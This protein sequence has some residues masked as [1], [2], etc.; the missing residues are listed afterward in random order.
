MSCNGVDFQIFHLLHF[1][2]R[3]GHED[4]QKKNT[5][6]IKF[7]D[8][9]QIIIKKNIETKIESKGGP[10]GSY[11]NEKLNMCLENLQLI[12]YVNFR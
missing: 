8:E 5:G 4:T 7:H 12:S 3:R 10:N 2:I 9:K 6:P 11:T 1:D